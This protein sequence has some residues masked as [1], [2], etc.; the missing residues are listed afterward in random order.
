MNPPTLVSVGCLV[1]L[2]ATLPLDRAEGE[3][4]P[5]LRSFT[6]SIGKYKLIAEILPAGNGTVEGSVLF[7]KIAGGVR[8]T[9]RI[10]GLRADAV[11]AIRIQGIT[12]VRTNT[13]SSRDVLQA[14]DLGNLMSDGNG[15]ATHVLDLD[16]QALGGGGI[17]GLTIIVQERAGRGDLPHDHAGD[18]IGAGV[19]R[20]AR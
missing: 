18:P 6:P 1:L 10:G 5:M 4:R 11:H 17:A 12:R 16:D 8:V 13:G 20:T 15:N 9:A 7:E 2:S 14:G 19:I 3:P